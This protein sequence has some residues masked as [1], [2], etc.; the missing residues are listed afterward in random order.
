MAMGSYPYGHLATWDPSYGTFWVIIPPQ[1]PAHCPVTHDTSPRKAAGNDTDQ[2][3]GYEEWLFKKASFYWVLSESRPI[4]LY[5]MHLD[6]TVLRTVHARYALGHTFDA[7]AD[8]LGF[9]VQDPFD[10]VA[11]S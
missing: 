9:L 5:G 1:R 4:L 8:E 7:K 11:R 2:G 3:C 10:H 6:R